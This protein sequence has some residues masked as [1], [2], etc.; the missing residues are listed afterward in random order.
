MDYTIKQLPALILAGYGKE[1]P[2]NE[3]HLLIPAMWDHFGK[4]SK[5]YKEKCIPKI[6]TGYEGYSAGL[7][8]QKSFYYMPALAFSSKELIAADMSVIE[9]PAAS[10]AVYTHEGSVA[11]LHK[12]FHKIYHEVIPSTTLK[13]NDTYDLEW[14]DERFKGMADDSALDIYIPLKD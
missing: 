9:I 8:V 5:D 6:C 11:H 14:Y 3:G 2:M 10:Y 1:V 7:K 13:I 4:W 12:T